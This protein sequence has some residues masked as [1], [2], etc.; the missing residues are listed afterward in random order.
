MGKIRKAM[1]AVAA[2]FGLALGLTV[3]TTAPE[4]E[5]KWYGG[6][7]RA[8]AGAVR[9]YSCWPAK[10]SCSHVLTR[11]ESSKHWT[12]DADGF[13]VPS[14]KKATVEACGRHSQRTVGPG[15]YKVRDLTCTSVRI[16]Y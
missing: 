13:Q 15:K 10:T 3:A 9:V 1:A 8:A 4:A 2:T 16:Y 12:S 14:G 6:E 5:A 11:G 7:I